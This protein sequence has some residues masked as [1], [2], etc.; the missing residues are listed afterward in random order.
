MANYIGRRGPNVS[1]YVAN[2]NTVAPEEVHD[3]SPDFSMF[4]DTDLFSEYDTT[5]IG[6]DQSLDAGLSG[7]ETPAAT[8]TPATQASRTVA[9]AS[10]SDAK[11]DFNFSGKWLPA[12]LLCRRCRL[13]LCARTRMGPSLFAVLCRVC[14]PAGLSGLALGRVWLP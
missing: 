8:T 9:A 14:W 3:S 6:F 5:S 10:A 1:Q 13:R 12:L 4:L 11:M 2:L 7:M